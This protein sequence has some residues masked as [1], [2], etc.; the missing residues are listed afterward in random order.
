MNSTVDVDVAAFIEEQTIF[1]AQD[2]CTTATA[3]L[4]MW[5]YLLTFDKEVAY[6]WR[7]RPNGACMLFL[8][9]RYLTIIVSIYDTPWWSL[10][11]A[12][13]VSSFV[14][15]YATECL[16]GIRFQ[17]C[18]AAVFSQFILEFSQY[19]VWAAFACLRVYALHRQW[20]WAALVLILSLAPVVA[21]VVPLRFIQIDLDP[22]TGC[23]TLENIPV[24]LSQSCDSLD[25]TS[26]VSL[27]VADLIVMGVTWSV[28]HFHRHQ[29]SVLRVY[30]ARTTLT[31]VLYKNGGIYFVLLTT[32][33][34]LHLLFSMLSIALANVATDRASFVVRFIEPLTAILI[35]RFLIELQE[36]SSGACTSEGEDAA[37]VGTLCFVRADVDSWVR[38]EC[39]SLPTVAASSGAGEGNEKESGGARWGEECMEAL[40]G[41]RRKLS[42]VDDDESEDYVLV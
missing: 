22:V 37:S 11:T 39:A 4:L 6:F 19:I 7:R 36:A 40:E 25:I 13:T 41:V 8:A 33:N 3:A 20:P 32:L 14:L 5:H 31:S 28:T 29:G 24:S 35:T 21:N 12:Y 18:A 15:F 38:S 16:L 27:I 26:R 34:S 2:Y 9:N 30:G 42:R 1:A 23:N 10:S 17:G